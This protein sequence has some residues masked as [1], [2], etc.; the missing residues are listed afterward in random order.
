MRREKKNNYHGAELTLMEK[1]KTTQA[2][3]TK[4]D[5]GVTCMKQ[6]I[7][8]ANDTI[9]VASIKLCCYKLKINE[10]K[11]NKHGTFCYQIE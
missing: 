3:L 1:I 7:D 2:P 5:G 6:H 8:Q 9:T 4:R 10:R 11:I